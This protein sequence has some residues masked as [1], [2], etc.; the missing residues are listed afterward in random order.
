MELPQAQKWAE[1][2]ASEEKGPPVLAEDSAC[3]SESAQADSGTVV[4]AQMP[5]TSAEDHEQGIAHE[6]RQPRVDCVTRGD[7]SEQG[8]AAR[9]S[10][11]VLGG[12]DID[13]ENQMAGPLTGASCA[14]RSLHPPGSCSL[15]VGCGA[16][17]KS[18]VGGS[19]IAGRTGRNSRRRRECRSAT[20]PLV[21][22]A[23]QDGRKENR[24]A[25]LGRSSGV[26]TAAGATSLVM[27]EL[28]TQGP[29]AFPG[30]LGEGGQLQMHGWLWKG[31]CGH[32][33]P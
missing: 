7:V 29:R 1:T 15:V 23:S 10:Q 9:G 12:S 21:P 8:V 25:S 2:P 26:S 24:A 4:A 11:E 28:D 33:A 17:S 3:P 20:L 14:L 13:G 6:S 30:L 32:A 5:V 31:D 27:T 16:D 22:G 19:R 18:H